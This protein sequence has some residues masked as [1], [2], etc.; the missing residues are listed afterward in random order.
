[1][2]N[3][4]HRT[5]GRKSLFLFEGALREVGGVIG[6]LGIGVVVVVGEEW[7]VEGGSGEMG[8]MEIQ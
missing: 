6:G 2:T 4:E 8:W 1:M 5:R 7:R 3:S